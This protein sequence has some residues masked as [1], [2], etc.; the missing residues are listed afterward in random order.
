MDLTRSDDDRDSPS[1]ELR[2]QGNLS[3][4]ETNTAATSADV[5]PVLDVTTLSD[6][7]ETKF[8]GQARLQFLSHNPPFVRR[9]RKKGPRMVTLAIKDG[10]LP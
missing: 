6:T 2:D 9:N 5:D 7:H 4:Q 3:P 1:P 10:Q 8:L